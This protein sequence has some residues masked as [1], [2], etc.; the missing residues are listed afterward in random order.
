MSS[1][2]TGKRITITSLERNNEVITG[3]IK[4]IIPTNE[5][6]IIQ[7]NNGKKTYNLLDDNMID[8]KNIEN[9]KISH[10]NVFLL[11]ET[12]D[13]IKAN[14]G[15]FLA[16]NINDVINHRKILK[17]KKMMKAKNILGN[18]NNDNTI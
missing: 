10:G 17:Y 7:F 16:L 9:L 12:Y 6:T 5:S 2:E 11:K 15:Y 3:V 1:V 14:T 4:R 8:D 18:N 13:R